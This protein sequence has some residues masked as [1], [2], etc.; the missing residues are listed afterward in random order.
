MREVYRGQGRVHGDVQVLDTEISLKLW[1]NSHELS[2]NHLKMH[3]KNMEPKQSYSVGWTIFCIHMLEYVQTT[4]ARICSDKNP[5]WTLL[6][7][8]SWV[9]G[10]IVHIIGLH[11]TK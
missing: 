3:V 4:H 2:S 11:F 6:F 9:V 7:G 5:D 1:P 8:T 10:V